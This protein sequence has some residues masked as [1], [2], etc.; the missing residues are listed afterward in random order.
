MVTPVDTTKP[1]VRATA[2]VM[3][4]PLVIAVVATALNMRPAVSSL[5]PVLD[6]VRTDLGMSPTVA[7]VLTAL[8][9]LCFAGVGAIAP[10]LTRKFGEVR[11]LAAALGV[12]AVALAV[13]ALSPNSAVFLLS[14]AF[15][16]AG[17]AVANVA[18]PVLIKRRFPSRVGLLTGVYSMA[19]IASVAFPA[20]VTIP[21]GE[22][23]GTGWR[24]GLGSWAL[25]AA[26]AVVPWLPLLGRRSKSTVAG[27]V[28]AARVSTFRLL[29]SR[30]A[31]CLMMF[32]GLQSLQV[33]VVIGWLPTILTDTGIAPATAAA[34]LAI[35]PVIAVPL[36]LVLPRTANSGRAA[37]SVIGGIVGT[38]AAGY[39][40]LLFAPAAAPWLWIVLLS[41]VHCAFPVAVALITTRARTVETV[42]GLSGLVNSGGYAL[43]AIGP[44]LLGALRQAT[45]GW[46]VALIALLALLA[47]ELAAG[48]L[49]ARPSY[50]ED[51]LPPA[52]IHPTP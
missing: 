9:V 33:Y 48:W 14:S 1:S 3:S 43:A 32:F 19:A 45:G 41:S 29:R 49:A 40:G 22:L 5:G 47:A 30:T 23:T 42:A 31:V 18:I 51:Q 25:L 4:V 2:A 7:G 34:M 27:P 52:A 12:I 26:V 37:S 15:A 8:P 6:Q 16:L 36:S 13:R 21:I 28:D 44:L 11:P 38:G 46:T 50:V 24:G 39:L 35:T 17:I 10:V 20:A